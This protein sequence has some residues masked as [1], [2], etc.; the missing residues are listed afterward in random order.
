MQKPGRHNTCFTS[1]LTADWVRCNS[2]DALANPPLSL[3]VMSHIKKIHFCNS[4]PYFSL[5]KGLRSLVRFSI[6]VG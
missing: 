4:T 6:R 2:W 5:A 3:F 1:I